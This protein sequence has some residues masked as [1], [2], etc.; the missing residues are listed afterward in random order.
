MERRAGGGGG[1]GGSRAVSELLTFSA[2]K[3]VVLGQFKGKRLEL[4]LGRVLILNLGFLVGFGEFGLGSADR[5][6]AAT[7]VMYFVKMKRRTDERT[8]TNADG[9][10]FYVA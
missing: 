4:N 6:T 10:A 3:S 5:A 9:K 2:I 7:S 8:R 1:G